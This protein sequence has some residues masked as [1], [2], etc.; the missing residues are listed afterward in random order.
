M[1]GYVFAPGLSAAYTVP[2]ADLPAGSDGTSVVATRHHAVT[3]SGGGVA[4]S[5]AA[6]P[7]AGLALAPTKAG[8][9]AEATQFEVVLLSPKLSAGWYLLG[10]GSFISGRGRGVYTLYIRV[11][12]EDPGAAVCSQCQSG[13]TLK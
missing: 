5:T 1:Y 10:A 6:V 13:S 4:S 8:E 9:V 7:A 3:S 11:V 2:L 12:Y